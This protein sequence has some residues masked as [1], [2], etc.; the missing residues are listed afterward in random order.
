MVLSREQS[1]SYD[2]IRAVVIARKT[3]DTIQ[4]L[5]SLSSRE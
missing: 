4:S 2:R 1:I 3:R 5:D